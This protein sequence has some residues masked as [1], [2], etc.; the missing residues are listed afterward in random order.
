MSEFVIGDAIREHEESLEAMADALQAGDEDAVVGETAGLVTTVA[1][2]QPLLGVLATKAAA[3]VFGKSANAILREQTAQWNRQRDRRAFINDLAGAVEV[4]IGQAL[5]QIARSQHNVK[6]E[7]IEALGG[8]RDDL[9]GFRDEFGAR[10]A[11]A[12]VRIEQALIRD[13]ATGAKLRVRAESRKVVFVSQ[14]T[15]TGNGTTG[16]VLDID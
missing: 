4:L 15:V 13:G 7:L 2:G 1:T 9:A 11:Q 5:V 14:G 16:V 8:I 6:D 10:L 3:R 12:D